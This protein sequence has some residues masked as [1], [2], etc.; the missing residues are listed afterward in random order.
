MG[1]AGKAWKEGLFGL[2]LMILIAFDLFLRTG[3]FLTVDV[4]ALTGSVAHGLVIDLGETKGV[5]RRGGRDVV[6]CT[7]P[8]L[9]ALAFRVKQLR[10]GA[11]KVAELNAK[12][13]S[14]WMRSSLEQFGLTH[15]RLTPYSFRRGGLSTACRA[16]V[17][18]S[19][20]ALRARWWD[21]KIAEVYINE[22]AAALGA[23][24]LSLA[25]RNCLN[26]AGREL[27]R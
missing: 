4:A 21:L 15:R 7:D 12:A 25:A 20:L 23:L 1:P 18:V 22:G 3:E 5:Q 6:T 13:F 14:K 17:P 8:E 24:Q 11:V 27:G 10:S 16:G 19:T 9:C 26:A 2:A